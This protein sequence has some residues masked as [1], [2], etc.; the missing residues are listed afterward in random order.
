MNENVSSNQ[1]EMERNNRFVIIGYTI[2]N[3]VLLACYVIEVVKKSRTIGY[4][5]IFAALSLIPLVCMHVIYR[6]DPSS[7]YVRLVLG[8]GYAIFYSFTVF[9][10]YS[11]VAFVY[12]IL[13]SLFVLVY[14]D[15]TYTKRMGWGLFIINAA[16]V[17]YMQIQ[18]K[19]SSEDMPNVEIRIGFV[20]LYLIFMVFMSNT[21]LKNNNDKLAKIEED[22]QR[23]SDMLNQIMEISAR[24]TGNI[25]VVSEKMD[26][27]ENSF[28]KTK[29]SMVEVSN[30]TNDTADSIQSQLMKTEEIQDFVRKVEV[31]TSQIEQGMEDANTEVASG[32]DKIDELIN[33]VQVSDDASKQVSAELDKLSEYTGQMQ[34][35]IELIDG[36]TSQTSLLSL[37]ASI[38]AARVGE[39]GKGFAVVASEISNLADQTQNATVDI[40]DLIDNISHEL[41]S[42]VKVINYLMDNSKLQGIAATETASSFETIASRTGDIQQQ[43]EDLSGLVSELASSNEAIVESIQTISA[44]TE[45]VTAHSTVTLEC[46]EENTTIVGDVGTVVE[47]LQSLAERLNALNNA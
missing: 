30:G 12:G 3:I 18:G 33:Q 10:T 2:Y 17:A 20:A 1:R 23:V 25:N 19:I 32:R 6:K 43:I 46:S 21:M 34:S 15:V 40:T 42:V 8:I 16:N 37:N 13:I 36:I 26:D 7:R 22:R 4:F 28:V 27:L 35:I 47:E 39:A 44:A 9:T 45:E 41:E 38:E 29:D 31:V 11:P 5:L 24:M 14:G